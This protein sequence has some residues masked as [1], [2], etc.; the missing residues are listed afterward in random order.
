MNLQYRHFRERD[1]TQIP[2]LFTAV[3]KSS[4]GEAEGVLIGQLAKDLLEQ[5]HKHDRFI[6][7][8]SHGDAIIGAIFVTRMPSEQER[9]L[10]LLA[11]VA[12]QTAYQGQGVG[13]RLIRYAIH[14]LKT[15]DAKTLVTYGD[16]NFYSKV[17][18]SPVEET[19]VEP[20]FPLS[21]P[22][23]W[24]AQPLNA[25]NVTAS[26]GKCSCVGALNTPKL[27]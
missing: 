21:Q 23:G 11:P 4:E 14:E 13:Q 27:W 26:L 10:W 8:A 5:T 2:A 25:K 19:K 6:F 24:L 7:V 9:E 12:V 22:E 17:G 16:P 3:F 20:P 1:S 18:F 15:T